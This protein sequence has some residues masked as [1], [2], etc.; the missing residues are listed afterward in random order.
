MKHALVLSVIGSLMSSASAGATPY[1]PQD[2]G[3]PP[4]SLKA[5]GIFWAGGKVVKRT[6]VGESSAGDQRALPI[7]EQDILVGQ[8]YVEYFIPSTL[9]SGPNTPPIVLVPGGALVGVH[10]LN[11][12]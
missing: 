10:F 4:L 11:Q 3:R 8:A 6:Q 7:R 5:H 2:Q 1:P 12:T 9:R